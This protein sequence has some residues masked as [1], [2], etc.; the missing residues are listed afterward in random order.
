[1]ILS[2]ASSCI[3]LVFIAIKNVQ[4]SFAWLD[5]SFSI[6][7]IYQ[8]LIDSDSVAAR[9]VVQKYVGKCQ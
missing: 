8:H 1:M 5:V 9:R 2:I 7:L 6:Q 4:P 3:A